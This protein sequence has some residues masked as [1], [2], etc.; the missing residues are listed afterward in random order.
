MDT[1]VMFHLHYAIKI[2]RCIKVIELRNYV[3]VEKLNFEI[4]CM[5]YLIGK[6]I[7]QEKSDVR[8]QLNKLAS[9]RTGTREIISVSIAIITLIIIYRY[10]LP[11]DFYNER[12]PWNIIILSMWW[13]IYMTAQPDAIQK[14][15]VEV[16]HTPRHVIS[17]TS[18]QLNVGTSLGGFTKAFGVT[19]RM[20][21][22][23]LSGVT[24]DDKLATK[25]QNCIDYM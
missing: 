20:F 23:Y 10:R 2:G 8:E 19:W 17:N 5:S 14:V 25:T 6:L 21:L 24:F 12:Y 1:R 4:Y 7:L 15:A 18:G 22:A 11:H 16:E 13:Q 9:I 3:A